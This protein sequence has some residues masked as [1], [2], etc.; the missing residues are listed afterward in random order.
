MDVRAISGNPIRLG[1]THR[2]RTVGPRVARFHLVRVARTLQISVLS[3]VPI[4]R[5]LLL[6]HPLILELMAIFL[7]HLPSSWDA[8]IVEI[9]RT[10]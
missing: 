7:A 10:L 5:V 8:S 3:R 9:S 2:S 1:V 6:V 4:I